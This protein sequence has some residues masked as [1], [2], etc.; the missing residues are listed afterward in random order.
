MF[1][2][3]YFHFCIIIGIHSRIVEEKK[4]KRKRD[5]MV[6]LPDM[7]CLFIEFLSCSLEH[8]SGDNLLP[9]FV[10]GHWG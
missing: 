10:G 6:F 7:R 4:E 8:E 1:H 5:V 9:I 3:C 2:V